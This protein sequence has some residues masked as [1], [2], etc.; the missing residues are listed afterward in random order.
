M[1][2][3]LCGLGLHELKGTAFEEHNV[4]AIIANNVPIQPSK[5]YL[6]VYMHRLPC[7]EGMITCIKIV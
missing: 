7:G 3:I 2:V 5:E 1:N 4:Q 6:A